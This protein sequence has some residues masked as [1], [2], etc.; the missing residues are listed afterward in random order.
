MSNTF[1]I[2]GQRKVAAE[3]IIQI[4]ATINGVEITLD[5]NSIYNLPG[6][7]AEEMVALVN[8]AR[9]ESNA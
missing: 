7:S 6:Y 2:I 5:D 4:Q 3:R 9:E 8:S 1:L